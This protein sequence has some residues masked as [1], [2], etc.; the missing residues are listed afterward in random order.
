VTPLLLPET[1]SPAIW[2][3]LTNSTRSSLSLACF[4]GLGL[5]QTRDNELQFGQNSGGSIRLLL[6]LGPFLSR[7]CLSDLLLLSDARRKATGRWWVGLGEVVV[8][9]GRNGGLARVSSHV[10]PGRKRKQRVE[11]LIT[12]LIIHLLGNDSMAPPDFSY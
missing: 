1:F 10:S 9:G 3:S 8:G 11:E 6:L 12:R 2:S 7:R 4:P 5:A